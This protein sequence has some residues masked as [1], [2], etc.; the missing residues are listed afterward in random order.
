MKENTL[1]KIFLISYSLLTWIL[2][3]HGQEQSSTYSNTL[4]PLKVKRI[5][6]GIKFDGVPDDPAWQSI[7]SLPMV[8]L[9]PVSGSEPTEKSAIKIAYDDEYFYVSGLLNYHDI[10]YIRSVGKKR[11]YDSK[12]TDWFGLTLD[13]FNDRENAVQFLTNPNGI[14]SDATIKNDIENE[15]NDRNRSWNTFWDVKTSINQ[16]RWSAEFRIPFSSLRF[17]DNHGKTLMGII[18]MRWSPAKSELSTFPAVSPKLNTP[19]F[20][21][22]LSRIIEFEGL[23]PRKP[24]YVTPYIIAGVGQMNELNEAGSAYKMN[25]TI[26]LDAGGDIKYSITNN[27]TCDLTVNTDFAQVEADDQ[28]INLTR[29]SLYFPEKRVFFLEKADVFD[30]SFLEGNN[31]FYSRRI[32]L[33][34][35]NS[36]R[37]YGGLRLTGR[38]KKWDMGFLD[39]QTAKF[40]DN[41][42]ENFGVLRLKR[43]VFNQ[44]SFIGGM[45][46]SKIGMNGTYNTAYG[47]DAQFRV[48]GDEY[49]SFKLAQTFE[50]KAAN[51]V[52]DMSPTRL[53]L[54][55]QRRNNVGLGYNFLYTYSGDSYNPAVGFESKKAYQGPLVTVLYGWLPEEEKVLRYHRLSL[56]GYN[57]KNT[58]TGIHETTNTTLTWYWEAKKLYGGTIAANWFIED[59]ADTL[60]LGNNQAHVPPGKYSFAYPSL[61][62]STSTSHAFSSKFSLIAGSFYD[63]WR[64]SFY[65]NPQVKIGTDLD[66][67]LTYYLDYV[68]FSSRDISF[69]NHIFGLTG[70]MTLTTSTSLASFIQYNT[71]INRFIMNVRFRYNPREGNDFYIVYD[72]GLNTDLHR[73]T[74]ELPLSTGRTILLKYTYTFRL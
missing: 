12:S 20:K 31:L 34:E 52:F 39:M 21:P 60:I 17:Q 3:S 38:I 71:A 28:K 8:M 62:Y 65:A 4:E 46:T 37:I 57:S 2:I 45:L 63:G 27:I 51:K 13:T 74:P 6:G 70:L 66:F 30:F 16:L 64:F 9:A 53:L 73:V 44:N 10:K 56:S 67:G 58:V 32:G 68:D 26:K 55:W 22:S 36:V 59:L 42:A 5:Y 19:Y 18:L 48:T 14:R 69:T 15:D 23:K 49:I 47:L 24:I 35:G 33:Y 50:D 43:N 41:P 25:S 72:E 40:E 29:Y 11:D 54:Q 7:Q 61:G 1:L